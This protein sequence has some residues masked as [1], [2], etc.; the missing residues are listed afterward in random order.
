MSAGAIKRLA[1][2]NIIDEIQHTRRVIR[3]WETVRDLINNPEIAVSGRLTLTQKN[4]QRAIAWKGV[5]EISKQFQVPTL[6]LDATLP[7]ESI[8]QVYHPQVEVVANIDVA[9]PPYVHIH[10]ILKA[11]TSSTKLK[12][13]KHIDEIRRYVLKRWIELG[14]MSTLVVCQMKVEAELKKRGLPDGITVAHYNDIAGIDDWRD[15]RLLILVGRTAPGPDKMEE[16][17][18]AL[19]GARPIEI[20]ANGFPWYRTVKRGIR[21]PDGSGI[22]TRGDLHPD[23]MVEAIRWQ[24]LEGELVQAL[25]RGRGVNRTPETPLDAD[26]LFDAALPITVNKVSIWE[27]PSLLLETAAEGVM[28][29]TPKDM[30]RLWPEIWPNDKAADRTLRQGVPVLPGFVQVSYQLKGPKMKLRVG[31]FDPAIIP[32]PHAWLETNLGPL[33]APA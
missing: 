6:L 17:A 22:G 30:V 18:G 24:V 25:G 1:R 33:V 12:N 31:Y 28:L 4:G 16:I 23:R 26:L 8:L 9:M 2:D 21:L 7:E 10:Q 11:P 19:S 20:E 27:R 13:E 5:A 29:I 15:V 14:C 32:D 3:I